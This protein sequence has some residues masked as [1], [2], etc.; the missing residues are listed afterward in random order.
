[1]WTEVENCVTMSE[2]RKVF[3]NHACEVGFYHKEAKSGQQAGINEQKPP[4][5]RK[6]EAKHPEGEQFR[7]FVLKQL[8]IGDK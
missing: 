3:E 7:V 5:N 4:H 2:K 6:I 8:H 1:M